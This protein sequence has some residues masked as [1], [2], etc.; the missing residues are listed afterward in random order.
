MNSKA[1]SL[2]EI[3]QR[4]WRKFL[5]AWLF[6]I[7]YFFSVFIPWVSSYPRAFF[8]FIALPA[9]LI[10][11]RLTLRSLG[12]CP[13]T[14]FQSFLLVMVAPFLIWCCVVFGFWGLT[15]RFQFR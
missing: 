15:T 6:P 4:H 8:I 10:C 13:T 14:R 9:Y 1:P 5:P 7:G 12:E 11:A 2:L 3:V